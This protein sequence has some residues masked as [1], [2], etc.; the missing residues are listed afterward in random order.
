MAAELTLPL[1]PG[2]IEA[3]ARAREPVRGARRAAETSSR[4]RQGFRRRLAAGLFLAANITLF[5]R[6]GDL[7]AA[8]DAIPIYEVSILLCLVLSLPE[9]QRLIQP[10]RL[11]ASPVVVCVLLMLPAV[12]LSQ[13]WQ[14]ALRSA[15][16]AAI[17]FAKIVV[18]FT[19]LVSIIDSA[20]RLDWFLK[21][22]LKLVVAV[23]VLSLLAYAGLINIAALTALDSRER[24]DLGAVVEVVKRLRGAGIFNDPND[25]CLVLCIGMSIALYRLK[26]ARWLGRMGAVAAMGLLLL[27]LVL[28][29]SR[30]GL[31]GMMAT[32][33]AVSLTRIGWKKT[34]LLGLLGLPFIPLVLAGRQ[35]NIDLTEDTAQTRIQLWADGINF[36]RSSPLF[37]IGYRNF[38]E[39]SSDVAHNSYLHCYA[40]LGVFGGTL[41]FGVFFITL[42][43]IRKM[44]M[45]SVDAAKRA[46]LNLR[47]CI[48][49]ILAGYATGVFSLSRAYIVPTYLVFGLAASFLHLAGTTG[50]A[51]DVVI[52]RKLLTRLGI[53]SAGCLTAI[54]LIVKVFARF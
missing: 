7:F 29:R 12:V 2:P 16:D 37:G 3:P 48:A 11:A 31:L 8:M 45:Q 33:G 51:S 32:L 10:R 6:P 39:E 13:L 49:G 17:D 30:G 35:A 44:P 15:L 5:I 53:A 34:A 14:L 43:T 25:L 36:V 47:P 50:L 38:A 52:N 19:L 23:T 54:Y 41:F 24:D 42:D 22:L 9:I 27:A 40:E 18:Y 1:F 28:T 4:A 20:A 26:H 46:A 21:W